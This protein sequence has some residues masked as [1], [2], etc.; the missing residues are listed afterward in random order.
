MSA[1]VEPFNGT[2]DDAVNLSDATGLIQAILH[3]EPEYVEDF[4]YHK[5]QPQRARAGAHR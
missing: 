4:D 1:T 3:V 2:F 5:L